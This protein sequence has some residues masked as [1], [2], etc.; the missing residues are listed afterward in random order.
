MPTRMAANTV[1]AFMYP[2]GRYRGLKAKRPIRTP[3]EKQRGRAPRRVGAAATERRL[4]GLQ[5]GVFDAHDRLAV[6]EVRR[7]HEADDTLVA[8]RLTEIHPERRLVAEDVATD[9]LRR[10]AE[11]GVGVRRDLIRH[12]DGGVVEVA[13]LVEVVKVLV[14]LLLA[15][16]EFAA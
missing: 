6:G 3:R 11:E 16:G 13:H 10:V 15:L 8:L 7:V 12:D 5:S 4:F 1:R 2:H 14:E 9:G